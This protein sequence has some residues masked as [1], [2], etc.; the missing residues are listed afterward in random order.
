MADRTLAGPVPAIGYIRVSW[1]R[2]DMIAPETQQAAIEACA[3]RKGYHLIDWVRDLDMTGRNFKRE[4]TSV[5]SR[6]KDGEAV[7]VLAWKYSRFGRDRF[8]NAVNIAGLEAAGGQLVS[9]TEDVDVATATGRFQRGVLL[10]VAAF[11]SDRAGETWAETHAWRLRHGLPA[12]GGPRFGYALLGRVPDEDHRGRTRHVKGQEERYAP[13]EGK[14]A[15]ALA[16]AYRSYLAGQG[17]HVIAGALNAAGWRTAAGRPWRSQG[18]RDVL[19]SGFGAGLLMVHDPSCACKRKAKC[20]ERTWLPGA[21]PPVLKP[22]EWEAYRARRDFTRELPPRSRSA[23]YAPSGLA[24]CGHCRSAMAVSG[25]GEGGEPVFVCTRQRSYKDCPG[26][27]AVTVPR[28]CAALR[29]QVAEWAA[30]VD[31]ARDRAAAGRTLRAGA[32]GEIGRLEGLLAEHEKVLVN[33]AVRRATDTLLGDEA[34]AAAASQARA[35][36][37]EV[38]AGLKAAR[39][40]AA[41][42]PSAGLQSAMTGLMQSWDAMPPEALNAVLRALVRR[43][44]V[45]RDGERRRNEKGHWEPVPVRFE[46]LPVWEADPWEGDMPHAGRTA[47]V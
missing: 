29:E 1:A 23:V 3:A 18:I 5:I 6:V 39:A 32:D 4:I 38:A 43:V 19:D 10:E 25:F 12:S 35:R 13:E 30:D 24:R 33:L 31:A 9:A 8:G 21:H 42:I 46:V 22:G 11:E 27:P 41:R 14:G 17:F 40:R 36:R 34:W 2:E 7:A 28:V 20:R 44:A 45:Y 26:R 15:Q 37:D 16:G 47:T